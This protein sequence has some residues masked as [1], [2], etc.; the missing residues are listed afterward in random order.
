MT[1]ARDRARKQLAKN[2]P[3]PSASWKT[4]WLPWLLLSAVVV[5]V[6]LTIVVVAVTGHRGVTATG[7][8]LPDGVQT[9]SEKDRTHTTAPVTYDRSPPA[10]GAHNPR[11]LN[12]GIYDRPVPNENAVHSL[13]HGAV[14]I[15]YQPQ[16]PTDSVTHL[17][18]LVTSEYSGPGRYVILSPYPELRAPVVATAWGNQ[19]D[20][21]DPMDPRLAQFIEY[22]RLGPQT[23]EPGAL[24]IGGVGQPVG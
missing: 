15:T 5:A 20:L 8:P 4:G 7:R 12:C 22:F 6:A 17:R 24:C 1:K 11:P 19:L 18:Q 10:G 23:L 21:Q 9:F 2:A 16:L 13:E 14:W 3:A